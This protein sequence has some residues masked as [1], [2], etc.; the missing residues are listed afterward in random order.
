MG[1]LARIVMDVFGAWHTHVRQ[2]G[3]TGL[4]ISKDEFIKVTIVLTKPNEIGR[5]N[6]VPLDEL[7]E[8]ND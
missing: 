7:M 1:M 3:V 5:H 4:K 8:Q 6:H 2:R